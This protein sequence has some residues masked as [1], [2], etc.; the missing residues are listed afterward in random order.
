MFIATS[1][2]LRGINFCEVQLN[3]NFASKQAQKEGKIWG[4]VKYIIG[5]Q[6][7]HCF[8]P[9]EKTQHDFILGDA[10]PYKKGTLISHDESIC[11]LDLLD[12]R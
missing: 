9:M 2:Q 10:S 8:F 3:T 7:H 6:I 11:P 1:C 4:K 5:E 12:W